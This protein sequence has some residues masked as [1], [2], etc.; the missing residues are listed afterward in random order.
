MKY[1][2]FVRETTSTTGTGTY[3]LGGAVTG[4]QTFVAGVGTGSEVTYACSDG[5]DWE[6]GQGT[7]TDA[8]PDTLSR[9]A[10][11]ASSN[12]GSAVNWGAGDKSIYLVHDA[13]NLIELSRIYTRPITPKFN[14]GY[15]SIL[16]SETCNNESSKSLVANRFICAVCTFP[17]GSYTFAQI[18]VNTAQA[19]SKARIGIYSIDSAGSFTLIEETGDIDTTTTGVKTAS[20]LSAVVLDGKPVLVGIMT[21]TGSVAVNCS[22]R[23][24]GPIMHPTGHLSPN[25]YG[26]CVFQ[27]I[28]S[29]GWTALPSTISNITNAVSDMPKVALK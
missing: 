27:S 4:R 11:L 21:D 15:A 5:T 7:V 28:Q 1:A 20:L 19:A 2:D 16:P 23:S 29:A 25:S 10:I 17:A 13:S 6:V 26:Q 12:S 18:E 14:S 22:N 24:G 3:S 9:T 8:T